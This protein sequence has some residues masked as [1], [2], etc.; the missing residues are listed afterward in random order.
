MAFVL[1]LVGFHLHRA[2][3]TLPPIC[4]PFDDKPSRIVSL[5]LGTDELLVELV[6]PERITALTYLSVNPEFSNIVERARAFPRHAVSSVEA[7]ARL[8]PDLLL[9]SV[10]NDPQK[11]ESL[12]ALGCKVVTV[13]GFESLDGIRRTILKVADAVG[14]REK[15]TALVERMDRTLKETARTRPQ[16]DKKPV[17]LY[18]GPGGYTQGRATV[19]HDLIQR[20]GG[21]NAAADMLH[22][23]GLLSLEEWLAAR[24]DVLLRISYYPLDPFVVDLF[25]AVRKGSP[26]AE[27]VMPSKLLTT[28]S[29]SSAHAVGLLAKKLREAAP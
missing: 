2:I 11:V 25:Q 6:P 24:P 27:V 8:R 12:R 4:P 23:L 17:V 7:V 21:I 13:S 28:V 3:N 22:G 16:G 9:S 20:A 29:P 14:E 26:P 15:G 5:S 18:A 10:Y 1:L 19:I